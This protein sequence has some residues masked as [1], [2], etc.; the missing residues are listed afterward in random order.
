MKR[1]I[2]ATCVAAMLVLST[3]AGFNSKIGTQVAHAQPVTVTPALPNSL[4][5]QKVLVVLVNFQDSPSS[6]PYSVS[7]VRDM[8]FG[9]VNNFFLEN[10]YQ[11]TWLTGDVYGWFNIALNS[12]GC[13]TAN[14]GKYANAAAEAAGANLLSYSRFVYVFPRNSCGFNGYTAQTN[15]GPPRVYLNGNMTF[16]V[17]AHELGHTFE[18]DHSQA[19]DCGA[20][21]VGSN[22]TMIDY[23]D[24]FDMM[25]IGTA[26]FNAYQKERLGWLNNGTSPSITTVEASGVYFIEPLESLS[27]GGPKALKILK[28]VNPVTGDKTW[29]YVEF[30]QPIGHDASLSAFPNV[31]N[32][33][34][35]HQAT[36]FSD[37]FNLFYSYLLDMTPETASW[38]DPALEVGR[39]FQDV[40]T[41]VTISTSSVSSSGASVLITLGQSATPTPTPTPTA[42]PTPVPT[43]SPTPTP[44]PTPS[45]TL[46]ISVS[47]D[48]SSYT[49]TQTVMTRGLV[50]N[51]ES[52]VAGATVNFTVIKSNGAVVTLSGI[53]SSDGSTTVKYRLNKQDPKGAYTNSAASSSKGSSA[54]ATTSFVVR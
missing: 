48:R 54:S 24:K 5:E 33:L 11:Q 19:L 14:I 43:P 21:S 1:I 27:G 6:Q 44:E 4:G 49:N 20:L 46:S 51:G 45:P 22:C 30:R 18:L 53:T 34:V 37:S 16:S 47:T 50:L 26:H 38:Y 8:V 35:I 41:G 9:S 39:A 29:Y 52:P 23:G 3:I 28:S 31:V 42:T 32:G 17:A 10:S 25:G 40:D 15:G 13:D 7:Q 2:F 36:Q 12:T